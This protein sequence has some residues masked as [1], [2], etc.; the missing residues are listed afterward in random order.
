MVTAK[1]S[2]AA[3]AAPAKK[4]P[5]KASPEARAA[6]N[7]RAGADK[8]FTVPKTIG[9]T[10]DR[11]FQLREERLGISKQ[12][13]AIKAEETFLKEHLISV[14]PKSDAVGVT[15]H[16]VSVKAVTKVVPRAKDWSALYAHI[17][18]EYGRLKKAGKD[19]DEAFAVMGRTLSSDVV[20][21]RW[22]AK[23]PVPG[24]ERFNNVDLSYSR[25][26]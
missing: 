5:S 2:P 1:K 18:A 16:L 4:A 20:K 9:A 10:A 8:K 22:E 26:S 6:R 23:L 12:A 15:G 11:W 17:V 7:V 19:P 14:L 3:K 24:V 13:D 25:V 21:Q